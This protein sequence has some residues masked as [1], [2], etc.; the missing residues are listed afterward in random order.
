MNFFCLPNA[1]WNQLWCVFFLSPALF[2]S[3]F[4]LGYVFSAQFSYHVH[5][6][7]TDRNQWEALISQPSEVI[8][9]WIRRKREKIR[10]WKRRARAF[11]QFT[12]TWWHW[13]QTQN[14]WRR[15][16]TLSLYFQRHND[17]LKWETDLS[18]ALKTVC[19]NHLI[20]L[21][22]FYHH[23]FVFKDSCARARQS[24]VENCT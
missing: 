11:V 6:P 8:V 9:C 10:K 20:S 19:G 1:M 17:T 16:Q 24:V 18:A 22:R 12:H 21:H 13:T 15:R 5:I 7:R 14:K 23:F 3:L 4:S 2:I